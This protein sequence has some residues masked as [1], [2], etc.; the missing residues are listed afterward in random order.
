MFSNDNAR[1][2]S[3][4]VSLSHAP[5]SARLAADE[6]DERSSTTMGALAGPHAFPAPP[7]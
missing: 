4:P 7:L 5:P 3:F 6:G 2:L 1:Q